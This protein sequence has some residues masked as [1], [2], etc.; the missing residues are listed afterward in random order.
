MI[1]AHGTLLPDSALP[2]LLSNLEEEVNATRAARSLSP[3]TV[4]R[5]VSA[6]ALRLDRGELD[7]LLAQY[8]PPGALQSLEEVRGLLDR[9]SLERRLAVELG[10]DWTRPQ[11]RPFGRAL[12]TPLGTLFHVAAGNVAGL[13]A[14]TAVE[15][16]LTGNVNLVK[17]PRE[18]R[19][20]TLAIFSLLVEQEPDLAPF[21]YAFDV[22]SSDA[23]T[24][25]ALAGLADGLVVWGGDR[26]VSACRALAPPGCRLIEWGH[27][28]GFAY[29]SGYED[30]EAELSALARHIMETNGLLCSSCQVIFLDTGD[31]EQGEAFCREFLP[32]LSR[33]HALCR[34]APGQ[35]AQGAL[36]AYETFLEGLIRPSGRVFRGTGCSLTLRSGGE[37]ELSPLHGNVL[38]KCLPRER[39]LPTLRRQKGRLQTAGL[40]CAPERREELTALLA[41][42]GVTR[43]TRAGH[44]SSAFPAENHDGEYPLRRY[45]R[46]VD[47]EG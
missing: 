7:G 16:L 36:Y 25:K 20:L 6:L 2:G 26:A 31:P 18:D 46:M 14:F 27:R 35:A 8:A 13:P 19:G 10:P 44:M 33:A 41:R 4:I 38:V 3:E 15:G 1:F 9:A 42:A 39:L 47:V 45:V 40:I 29:L 22:P 11:P 34:P 37:L 23:A 21:L 28:L 12:P 17:L 32:Y 24:L 5:A 43:I 30:R